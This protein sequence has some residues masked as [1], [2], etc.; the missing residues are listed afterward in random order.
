MLLDQAFQ[1]ILTRYPGPV[2]PRDRPRWLGNAG[3]LSG[4]VLWRYDSE[5]GP[6]VARAW[7]VQFQDRAQLER[8][9]RWVM[10][11]APLRF[12]PALIAKIDGSTMTDHGGRFWD[13][14]SWLRGA[15]DLAEP[16]APEH[17]EAAFRGLAEF[18]RRLSAD[19]ASHR[20][21][22]PGLSHRSREI[23]DL[24]QGGF[25]QLETVM[26][27]SPRDACRDLAVQWLGLARLITPGMVEPARRACLQGL[28]LQPCIRDARRDHFLFEGVELTGIVDFGA[29]DLDSVVG[30]LA[31]LIGDW[32]GLDREGSLRARAISSYEKICPLDHDEKEIL[33]V[34]ELSNALLA[35]GRWV[36]WHFVEGRRFEDPLAVERGLRRGLERFENITARSSHLH[37]AVAGETPAPQGSEPLN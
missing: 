25:D 26:A 30:D 6:L 12:V 36:R 17:V 10:T 9:Q 5:I 13:V 8:I 11:A 7:P 28:R 1:E 24:V 19:P 16:P 35:P 34:F 3:G 27:T 37:R 29:M 31:R 32:L 2:Q 4:A 23:N 15:P 14:T 22:S 20:G 33:E 21:P 18:H